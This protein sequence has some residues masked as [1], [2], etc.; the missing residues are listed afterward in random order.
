MTGNFK[1]VLFSYLFFIISLNNKD[2]KKRMNVHSVNRISNKE[3]NI[4]KLQV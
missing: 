1:K 3:Q 4:N 2:K